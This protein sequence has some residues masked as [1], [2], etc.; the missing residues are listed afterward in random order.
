MKG[1]VLVIARP[2][3]PPTGFA[4]AHFLPAT[5]SPIRAVQSPAWP[6][7]LVLLPI[8]SVRGGTG[9]R[10]LGSLDC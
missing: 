9:L 3:R 4:D 10:G 7:P 5:G 1:E 2:D 6:A 8:L